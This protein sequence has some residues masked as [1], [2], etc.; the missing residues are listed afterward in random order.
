MHLGLWGAPA[1]FV[2]FLTPLPCECLRG[3][4]GKSSP[5]S[6]SCIGKTLKLEGAS[7]GCQM[8]ASSKRSGALCEGS[9]QSMRC[10]AACCLPAPAGQSLCSAVRCHARC[11]YAH[12][13]PLPSCSACACCLPLGKGFLKADHRPL[14]RRM[15]RVQIPPSHGKATLPV[16]AASR[17]LSG[18]W[19][20]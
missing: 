16:S 14:G 12:F 9:A 3:P 7:G 1:A 6:W 8:R 15:S 4:L 10:Q 17:E 20:S 13:A 19:T 5:P 2:S 18:Q 11:P